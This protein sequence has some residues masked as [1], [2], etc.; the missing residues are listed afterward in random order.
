MPTDADQHSMAWLLFAVLAFSLWGTYGVALHAGVT[1]MNPTG[2]DP[3]A[4]YKAYLFVGTAYFVAAIIAPVVVMYFNGATWNFPAKGVAMSLGAGCVGAMGAFFVLSAMGS[5]ST[6]PW[7]IPVVMSTVFAG[8]PIVNA[9]VALTLHPPE[10]GFGAIRWPFWAGIV[11]AAAG[12]TLVTLYKP[13]P[14][15]AHGPAKTETAQVQPADV[16]ES[17]VD[18]ATEDIVP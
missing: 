14:G 6:R 12:A 17:P 15:K 16:E 5:V 9:L 13:A 7:M 3:N 2:D 18:R 4:R 1:S 8:A 10:G 11:I